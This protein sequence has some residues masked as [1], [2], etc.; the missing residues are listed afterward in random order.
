M[1]GLH[2]THPNDNPFLSKRDLVLHCRWLPRSLL[3]EPSGHPCLLNCTP[4]L[5]HTPRRRGRMGG[6][7]ENLNTFSGLL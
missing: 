1:C 2:S 7:V 3:F 6:D 5:A 4:I